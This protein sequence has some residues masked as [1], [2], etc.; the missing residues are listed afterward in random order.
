MKYLSK[1]WIKLLLSFLGGAVIGEVIDASTGNTIIRPYLIWIWMGI[2][3]F[4]LTA[5]VWLYNWNHAKV[6]E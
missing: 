4:A 3:Y 5:I 2:V 1:F 6:E